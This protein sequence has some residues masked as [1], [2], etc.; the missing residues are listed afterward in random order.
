MEKMQT[1]RAPMESSAT[2]KMTRSGQYRKRWNTLINLFIQT[3]MSG[4]LCDMQAFEEFSYE[5]D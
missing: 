4:R 5:E 1:E 2:E 3:V